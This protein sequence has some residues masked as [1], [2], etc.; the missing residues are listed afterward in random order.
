MQFQTSLFALLPFVAAAMADYNSVSSNI[1]AVNSAVV[2]LNNQLWSS[3]V[4]TYSGAL[5]VDSAAKALSNKLNTAA[6]ETNKESVFAVAP[7]NLL[8]A[9]VQ[10]MYPSV[11]NATQRVA[12]LEPTFKRMGVAGIAKSDVAKLKDSTSA[13][14]ASLVQC[15]PTE[16]RAQ[17]SSLANAF[18]AAMASALA[19]YASD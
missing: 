9:A 14:A 5:G 1:A 10:N 4:A 7:S 12:A 3:N 16:N 6:T 2:S 8:V 13:F 15:T 11:K 18:N 19:A 17:A